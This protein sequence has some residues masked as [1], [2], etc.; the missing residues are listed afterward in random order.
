MGG[1]NAGVVVV[2]KFCKSG[3]KKFKEYINYIDR[4]EAVRTEKCSKYNLYQ[5]YM[6]NPEKTTGLFTAEKDV[7]NEKEKKQLKAVFEQA[8]KNGSLMWQTVI[9]FDNRWLEGNGLYDGNTQILDENKIKEAARNSVNKMLKAEGLENAVWSGAIHFN[10]DNV[11][12][13]IATIEPDPMREKKEYTQYV[14]RDVNGKKVK[15]PLRDDKG[16]IIKTW[17]YKGR[18]KQSSIDTC[19]REMV[20][21]II[22]EKENNLKI[23]SIIRDSII[24]QKKNHVL[25]KD[26]ELIELFHKLYEKMPDCNRNMWNYNNPI[27]A[28]C[29]EIIDEISKQYIDNY[30]KDEMNELEERIMIQDEKYKEAYGSSGRSYSEGKLKDLYTRMGNV[31]LKELREYDKHMKMEQNN[32]GVIRDPLIESNNENVNIDD[33]ID[34]Y[35]EP[36]VEVEQS[37]YEWS[38]QYKKAKKLLHGREPNYDMAYKLLA[39][40]HEKGNILASYELGDIYRY[41]RGK[42]INS[43]I[44]G[45]YYS[46]ALEGFKHLY[47]AHAGTKAAIYLAYRIGKQYYYG[48]G[49]GQDYVNAKEWLEKSG[50]QYAKYM[51]G[52]MAYYGQGMEQDYDKAFRYF[53]E[54]EGNA[55]ATYKAASMLAQNEVNEEIASNYNKDKLYE[56]AFAGFMSMENKQPDDN[57]EYRIGIMYLN[58]L[59]T[60]QDYD[61]A[62]EYLEMA[63]EAGNTY[64]MNRLAMI[65]IDEGNI[66]MLP[67]AIDYLTKAATKG[68]NC[69]AQYT[70]GNIYSSDKY[71][72]QDMDK[73]IYWYEKAESGGNEFASY[74]LGKIYLGAKDYVN[75]V[76]HLEMCNNKY[77]YYSLAKIYL[78]E[79]N[80]M[81]N[82]E[83]GI[84]YMEKAAEEGNQFAMYRMGNIYYQ[85][86]YTEKDIDK[87]VYWYEKAENS[88][89]E[90]A[91]F[92]LGKIYYEQKDY[93]KAISHFEK[94]DNDNALYLMGKMYLDKDSNIFNSE[95][96]IGYMLEAAEKGNQYAQVNMGLLYLKGDVVKP[97]RD[98]AREWFETARDNGSE[99]ARQIL[100]DWNRKGN[101]NNQVNL[102]LLLRSGKR[103]GMILSASVQALKRAMKSEWQ[104]KRNEMEHDRLVEANKEDERS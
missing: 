55:Y 23:N 35:L 39:E 17:E 31:V 63:A 57:L 78:D 44:A 93:E 74:K 33:D 64:A 5:D 82:P 43:E 62:K 45:K 41:G 29:R 3:T 58:G 24:K 21:Q 84:G 20:N 47:N 27:V 65:Y 100:S 28:S 59:G 92:R 38:D 16:E 103:R 86:T 102:N 18:F 101:Y 11:H 76:K 68:K 50:N 49:T 77:A 71:G 8:E 56:R 97:H 25:A 73:A 70:L 14:T 51:L 75:A 36:E 79:T 48:L 13:H 4:D 96:G 91:S 9:S 15:E 12:V 87:A 104:K 72:M 34:I 95:K 54:I 1:I 80:E 66:E 7:L 2:T 90:Y 60:E 94:C 53:V 30:H 99:F 67:K 89:N 10:T 69:M 88:G 46:N 83:K 6:G 52:K 22:N 42:E 98:K 61:K 26:K 85:G 40:E 37:Y 81:F 19:K 32:L